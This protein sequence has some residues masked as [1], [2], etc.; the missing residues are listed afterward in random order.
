MTPAQPSG[1]SGKKAGQADDS[2]VGVF[3]TCAID[4][5]LPAVGQATH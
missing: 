5:A 1:E 3:A 2:A 4:E